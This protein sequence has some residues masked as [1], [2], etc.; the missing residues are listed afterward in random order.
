MREI[1]NRMFKDSVGIF[2]GLIDFIE[3]LMINKFE[4]Q[5]RLQ[6]EEIKVYGLNC[7]F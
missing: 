1:K 5:F 3:G 2:Q 7:N 6:L 4:R